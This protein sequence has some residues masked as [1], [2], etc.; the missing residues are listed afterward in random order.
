MANQKILDIGRELNDKSVTIEEWWNRHKDFIESINEVDTSQEVFILASG[1]YRYGCYLLN[2]GYAAKVF[3]FFNKA[4]DIIEANKGKLYI[5]QYTNSLEPLLEAKANLAFKLDKYLEAYQA[6]QWLHELNFEKDD[7]KI[8][9]DSV[10]DIAVTK[11]VYPGYII[12]IAIWVVCFLIEMFTSIDVPN[13]IPNS[14]WIIWM[15]LLVLQFIVP[16][17]HKALKK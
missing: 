6:F 13:I 1:C 17:M 14:C 4:I 12:V 10:F 7:Y 5:T 15:L 3:P 16:K 11:V 9:R 2:N 8:S